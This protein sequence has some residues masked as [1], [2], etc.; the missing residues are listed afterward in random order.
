[1]HASENERNF[2]KC[3][4]IGSVVELV[5]LSVQLKNHNK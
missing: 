3:F 4:R 1:M 2:S 5:R